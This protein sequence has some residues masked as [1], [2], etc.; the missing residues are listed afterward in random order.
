MKI[1]WSEMAAN[2]LSHFLKWIAQDSILQAERIESEIVKE[3][4]GLAKHPKRYPSDKFKLNNGGE[5]RAFEMFNVRISY[6][7]TTEQIQILRI[8]HVKQKPKRF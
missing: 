7:I 2:Q 5:F 3:I 4:E 6:K 8:R 1:V